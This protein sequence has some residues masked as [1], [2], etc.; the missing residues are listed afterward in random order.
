MPMADLN[1]DTSDDVDSLALVL[2]AALESPSADLGE[3]S[4][5]A[6][7]PPSVLEQRVADHL[8]TCW[9]RLAYGDFSTELAH[10]AMAVVTP[11]IDRLQEAARSWRQ[12]AATTLVERDG[13]R[14]LAV[15]L[16]Q[17]NAE[18][19]RLLRAGRP[20]EALAVLDHSEAL[21]D[22]LDGEK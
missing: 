17:A 20:D 7:P 14:D 2:L 16:E 6:C 19:V 21:D 1:H 4:M 10:N 9:P 3:D 15:T 12:R 18:A 13:A 11:V 8:A 5:P 22:D